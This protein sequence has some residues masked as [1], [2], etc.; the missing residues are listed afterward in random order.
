M[1]LYKQ[2]DKEKER[3]SKKVLKYART[4]F[5][6]QK[7]IDQWHESMIKTLENFKKERKTFDVT[8]Y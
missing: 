5:S 6:Y 7:T 4:E 1:K 3:L 8:V 2:S